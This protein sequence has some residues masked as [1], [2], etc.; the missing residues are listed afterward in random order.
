MSDRDRTDFL[1]MLDRDP[2]R[3]FAEFYTYA[4]RL[5]RRHPPLLLYRF[6]E[7]DRLDVLHRIIVHCVLA[8]FRVLRRY[9]PQGFT[10]A[11][12]FYTVAHNKCNDILRARDRR[13]TV[14]L[15]DAPQH[16]EIPDGGRS[17]ADVLTDTEVAAVVRRAVGQL[18]DFCQIAVM[19]WADG[20]KP[21]E[22]ALIVGVAREQNKELSN[23]IRRCRLKLRTLL[24]KAGVTNANA[25]VRAPRLKMRAAGV[26]EGLEG[27]WPAPRESDPKP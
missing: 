7:D 16:L 15:D 11:S 26:E 23:R 3:A 10:F 2:E 1:Q 17:P 5:F 14:S 12:W 13:R 25:D 22:I 6:D 8:D 19:A 4:M 20:Y 18:D 24:A 21:Q 9:R 27:S